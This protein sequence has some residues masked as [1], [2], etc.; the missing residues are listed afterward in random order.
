MSE[1]ENQDN[2]EHTRLSAPAATTVVGRY[3]VIE[4]I[5]AGGMGEVYLAFDPK[6]Q[7]NVAIKVLPA[8]LADDPET[9]ARFVREAQTAA[10]LNHN[11]I[12]TIYEVDEH[13]GRHFIAMELVEGVPLKDLMKAQRLPL[14]N[15]LDL[16]LQICDGLA[17]AHE[18]KI[19]HRDIKPANILVSGK[20]KVKILDFGLAKMHSVSGLTSTGVR[21]GTIAYMSPEQ[22]QGSEVDHRSDIFSLGVVFYEMLAGQPPFKKDSEIATLLAILQLPQTPLR[23]TDPALPPEI[24]N[25]VERA[26]QKDRALRYQH[27][28]ELASDLRKYMRG[29]DQPVSQ[30]QPIAPAVSASRSASIDASTFTKTSVGLKKAIAILPFEN[31]GPTEHNYFAE[32]VTEEITTS[33][34]KIKLLKVI[35]NSSAR[36]FKDK[37]R[38]VPEIASELGVEF[39]LTGTIRWDNSQTPSRFRLSCK[40]V[41]T[42]DESY[43]WAE[44]YDRVLEE[45]FSLQS[46]L[47]TEITK[48]LGVALATPE[49]DSLSRIPTANLEAYD[50]YLRGNE[51]YPRSTQPA[52]ISKAIE[53]Y[54]K[55]VELDP[56]FALAHVKL[57]QANL[58]MYWF[59]HDRTPARVARAKISVDA[60]VNVAPQLPETSLALGYYY[61]YGCKDYMQA[62]EQF[63]IAGKSRPNDSSLMAATGFIQ[64]RLGFWNE[65]LRN[66]RKAAELDPK[67][68]LLASELGNTFMLL[69]QYDAAM[70]QF[71][72]AI[73]LVPD[74]IDIYARKAQIAL[75][76]DGNV[77]AAAQIFKDAEARVVPAEMVM[78]YPLL[79]VFVAYCDGDLQAAMDKLA[80]DEVEMELY[81]INKGRLARRAGRASESKSYFES[82]RVMLETKLKTSPED[83]RY[84]A[85]LGFASAGLGQEEKALSCCQK[86]IEL[87]PFDRDHVFSIVYL[88]TYA[89]ALT[90]LGRHDEAIEQLKFLLSVPSYISRPLLMVAEDFVPLRGLPAFQKLLVG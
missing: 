42:K 74:W 15:C 52:D 33:L 41:D 26:L 12:V 30:I 69:R 11:N 53:M 8:T 20:G 72:R 14:Q 18:R 10:S 49:L 5:G 28:E 88:E 83:A 2:L 59:F 47:A 84:L 79:D 46:E 21:L 43:L 32:G 37:D 86:A 54:E 23:E 56:D 38:S 19:V 60:A 68:S 25:I 55:A 63:A 61:Y 80:I 7:R 50:Y 64:R 66:I 51:F 24:S 3:R 34:A 71:D 16:I 62:L 39:L 40:L 65:A 70:I 17:A 57:A 76:R 82:A 29:P 6:L 45:I 81:F 73:W 36:Q 35:S 13:E 4:K 77:A 48:A 90:A 78:E 9:K 27:I 85:N 67:S 1:L 87:F 58:S 75:L 89:L 22:A 44:S 31:L